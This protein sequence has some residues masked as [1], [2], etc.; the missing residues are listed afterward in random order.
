MTDA[1]LDHL[2]AAIAGR[3]EIER[4]VGSGGMALV[5]LARDV[6]HNRDVAIKVLRPEFVAAVGTDRFLQEI[7]VTAGLRHP[8]ILPLHDSGEVDGMLF[9]VMPY[10]DGESLRDKLNGDEKLSVKESVEIAKVTAKAL[11]YAH[12]HGVVHRDI[13]PGNILLQDGQP[14]VADFG[15][16]LAGIEADTTRLT[17]I[18]MAIGTPRYMSPE[19]FTGEIDVDGRSDVYSLGAVLY[20]MLTGEPPHTGNTA[21]A[22]LGRMLSESPTPVG[23][24][25][26][27]VPEYVTAA[28]HRSLAK[29]PEDRF[30]TAAEFAAAIV[31]DEVTENTANRSTRL[32][33]PTKWLAAISSVVAVAAV[34]LWG[35]LF[36][37]SAGIKSVAVLPLA[38]LSGDSEQ[39]VLVDGIHDALISELQQL[40]AFERVISRTSVLQFRDTERPVPEIA[41]AL[42]VDAVIE[43]TVQ[44]VDDAIRLR[45]TLIGAF[46]E[47]DLWS[48]EYQRD[49]AEVLTL[50]REI[51]GDI[52]REI[53]LTLTP[54]E[55]AHLAQ[56]RSV[57]PE[58]FN[59]VLLGREAWNQ[60]DGPGMRR[61]VALFNQAVAIDS[62]YAA[63][64]V[65]LSDSYNMLSQY[66]HLPTAEGIPLA[67]R[68]AERALAFDSTQGQ[69]YT[70]LAEVHFLGREW[71]KAEQAYRRAIA[72]N[73]GSAIGYHFFGWFLSHMGRHDE[74]ISMLTRARELD[75]LSAPINA[76]LAAVY[77]HARQ[78][79]EA[80]TE[81][82]RTMA[83]ARGFHRGI[84]LQVV[85]GVLTGEEPDRLVAD[86]IDLEEAGFV[87]FR[88]ALA[89]ALAAAGRETEARTLLE[90][91]IA[92]QGG[93]ERLSRSGATI[94]ATA[95]LELGDTVAA[96][97][98][99]E[100]LVEVG[101]AAGLTSLVVWPL[102]DPLREDPRFTDLV[103]KMGYPQ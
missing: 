64:H 22:I 45:V 21:K 81:T 20:E 72:L 97:S 23:D 85:L 33:F 100:R 60:R 74:A 87:Y 40:S 15:I 89:L 83:I 25:R 7:T 51:T 18:G 54:T 10:F 57:N 52:A 53:A 55:E 8:N 65:G 77:L 17:E 14:V 69:A 98:S 95:Y 70:S 67:L 1:I 13:K 91:A 84:W 99:L 73:P 61:A 43:G 34:L 35:P 76:D 36:S 63:A 49:L 26:D 79:D 102:F 44:R 94:A 12:R 39:D 42:N 90:E 47:R 30:Q 32:R 27:A 88:A 31:G 50:Q 9:Y 3:Y 103:A 80:W 96:W 75:P 101:T 38:N 92:A 2:K 41:T 4:E 71:D 68:S 62:T 86:A 28:V 66:D 5:Y 56:A 29:E 6:K 93:I 37:P 48:R 59:L 16:A 78:Y 58:A 24:L 82:E 11:D 19:Q 46:P